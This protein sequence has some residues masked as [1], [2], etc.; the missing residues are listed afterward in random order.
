MVGQDQGMKKN[1]PTTRRKILTGSHNQEIAL[2][3][4][5]PSP[6]VVA[7]GSRGRQYC[8][9]HRLSGNTTVNYTMF[10]KR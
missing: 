1:R 10:V 5:M 3:G 8:A 7:V 2:A 4:E 6:L 9:L